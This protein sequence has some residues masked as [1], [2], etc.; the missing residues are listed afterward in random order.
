MDYIKL[1]IDHQMKIIDA[2]KQM[3]QLGKKL[4]MVFDGNAFKSVLSIGDIQRAIIKN[5]A[6]DE[7][8]AHILREKINLAH[9]NESLE[10]IKHKMISY[11]MEF[12]PVLNDKNELVKVYFWEDFFE[13]KKEVLKADLNVPVVIM[14]GGKG[15]R[16]QPITNVLPKP[17]IPIGEKTILEEIMDQFVSV[18][19]NRFYMSVNYKAD[20]IRYY[21]D[22]L[23]NPH[24]H[25]EYFKENK[26]LGTAG[27]L[28]LLKDVLQESF[29]MSNCDIMIDQ[30]LVDIYHYHQENKNIIT[31]VSALKH[32]KIPYGTMETGEEGKL[33]VLTEKPEITLK[34]NSGVYI[35]SPE[36]FQYIPDNTHIHITDII[37]KLLEENKNVGVFPV[38]EL[39]WKDIGEWNEYL[40]H[41]VE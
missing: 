41:Y 26:P 34:I 37:N 31:I 35:L 30:D 19:S 11:R 15:K 5:I 25:I 16:L 18:G 38:S 4:L 39:S 7:P 27:S 17:L 8:V 10:E 13:E 2:L 29:F 40:R 33:L 23:K 12:L 21:F 3:D 9:A 6:L 24:Y 14:A 20:M 36:V 1:I 32:I 28:Y 22:N